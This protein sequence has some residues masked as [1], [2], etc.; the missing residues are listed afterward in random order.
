MKK[1][2]LS[3]TLLFASTLISSNAYAQFGLGRALENAIN[4]NI[5]K[6]IDQAVDESFEKETQK[7]K[8]KA[9]KDSTNVNTDENGNI[10][11]ETDDSK[12][13][14]SGDKDKVKITTDESD[15]T[16]EQ[17]NEL[18]TNVKPSDFIGSFDAEMSRYKNNQLKDKPTNISY[19]IDTYKLA[20]EI[21]PDEKKDAFVSI[22]DRQKGTMT[23][24]QEEKGKKT[25][26]VMKMPKITVKNKNNETPED[27]KFTKTGRTKIIDGH[28]CYE[29]IGE[30]E[31]QKTTFWAAP[32]LKYNLAE[33]MLIM[34]S[35][36]KQ[37]NETP[38]FGQ[39]DGMPLEVV[40][41]QLDKKERIEIKY[42]NLKI[43]SV[44]KAKF[45]TDGYEITD[46]TQFG[47]MFGK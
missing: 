17:T 23:M 36:N 11:I 28:T 30:T 7:Q 41:E 14:I 20:V 9:Q 1:F 24:L 39:V 21:Q 6:K 42:K 19:F 18:P 10:I 44:N 26:M 12:V 5:E 31:K 13:E 38:N 22:F 46:M 43:G 8:N 45:S 35:Q 2:F 40:I 4:R 34:Q 27:V 15:V 32:D 37:Q 3:I 16:I 33:S 29:Y 47:G 25:A